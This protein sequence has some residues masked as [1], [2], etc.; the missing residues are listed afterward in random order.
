MLKSM[1]ERLKSL[2]RKIKSAIAAPRS[3]DNSSPIARAAR[4][5]KILGGA[6]RGAIYTG[7]SVWAL[8]VLFPFFWML[9]TSFKSFGSYN[10]ERTPTFII[11]QP[12]FD[13]Y[14]SAFTEA[15]LAGYFLNTLIFTVATTALMLVITIP[16]SYAFARL[17]FKGKDIAFGQGVAQ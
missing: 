16:A 8:A 10:A 1:L 13:N 7:L 3:D 17:S 9:L 6:K 14:I 15:N 2:G 12:T 4:R 5:S 11:R